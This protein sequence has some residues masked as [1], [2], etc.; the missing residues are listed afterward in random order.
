MEGLT[1]QTIFQAAFWHVLINQESFI[2]IGAVSNQTHKV[3]MAKNYEHE[4]LHQELF[5]PL[6]SIPV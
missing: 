2:A 5:V 1:K 6:K 3:G 4:N